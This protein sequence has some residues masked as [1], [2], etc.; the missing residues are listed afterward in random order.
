MYNDIREIWEEGEEAV[1]FY[2]QL[3]ESAN[4]YLAVTTG[5]GCIKCPKDEEIIDASKKPNGSA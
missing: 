1:I 4:F 2:K 5:G 3:V